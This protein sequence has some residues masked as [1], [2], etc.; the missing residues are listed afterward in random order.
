MKEELEAW[1]VTNEATQVKLQR[2]KSSNESLQVSSWCV[3]VCVVHHKIVIIINFYVYVFHCMFIKMQIRVLKSEQ[4]RGLKAE[5]EAI[6]LREKLE[7]LQRLLY[8]VCCKYLIIITLS[9]S[10]SPLQCAATAGR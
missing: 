5:T 3:C 4:E 6:K 9:C 10:S 7:T 2:Q 1:Q 8:F